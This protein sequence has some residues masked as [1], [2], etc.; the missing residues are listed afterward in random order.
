ML[1]SLLFSLILFKYFKA[2]N[3]MQR[4]RRRRRRSEIKIK[5]RRLWY[6]KYNVELVRS[7][8]TNTYLYML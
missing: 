6:A 5:W 7:K 4:V 2:H 8:K 3:I 1:A